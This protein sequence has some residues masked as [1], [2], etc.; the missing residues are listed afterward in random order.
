MSRTV[1]IVASH[2]DDEAL[3]C[4]GTIARHAAEGDTVHIVL[5]ADGVTS[6]GS[7]AGV[8]ERN[9]AAETAAAVLGARKPILMGLADNRMDTV[10][11][12]E[13]V[14]KL[15]EVMQAI[16]PELIYTHHVGD[17][18]VDHRLTHR[19]V[20]IA[21]RPQPGSKVEAIYGFEVL[22]STE[23]A[24]QGQEAVFRPVHYVDIT[25]TFQKKVKALTAYDMEMRDA[26]HARSYLAVEAKARVRGCEVGV[27]YAEAFTVIRQVRR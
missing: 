12:L 16:Q 17:L 27:P 8:A 20:L 5:M 21:G 24:D 11:L 25:T 13:I 18:N 19:A 7:T 9:K 10:P 2:A 1:L 4:G 6:R 15:E 22:S 23:W 14:R 3:G 26:P